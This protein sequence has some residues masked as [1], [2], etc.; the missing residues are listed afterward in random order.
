MTECKA[1]NMFC[2]AN[3]KICICQYDGDSM[4]R[5]NTPKIILCFIFCVR[6]EFM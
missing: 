5:E 6:T 2:T 1:N 3:V 4:K